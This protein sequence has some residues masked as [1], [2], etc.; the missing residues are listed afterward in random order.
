MLDTCLSDISSDPEIIYNLL[1]KS[2]LYTWSTKQQYAVKRAYI[3]ICKQHELDIP[4]RIKEI[5]L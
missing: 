4:H 1:V 5:I 3:A 2:G